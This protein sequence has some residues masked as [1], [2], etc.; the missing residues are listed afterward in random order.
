LSVHTEVETNALEYE[1]ITDSLG[2]I[3]KTLLNNLLK[4]KAS[5]EIVRKA[6]T[7][8]LRSWKSEIISYLQPIESIGESL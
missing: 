1:L 7:Q 6:E 8:R 3:A 4:Q 2:A 5:Q